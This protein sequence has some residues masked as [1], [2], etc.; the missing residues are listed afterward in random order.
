MQTMST[1]TPSPAPALP[2]EPAALIE[3]IL[4]RFHEVHRQQ[5]PE[6]IR[7]ATQVESRHADHPAA[8][9]GLATLLKSMHA[10]LLQ[11]MDKEESI[12]F[13]MLARGGSP[14]VVH[15]IAVMRSEHEEHVANLAQ[16]MTLTRHAEPPADA[17]STWRQLCACVRQFADDLEQHI[18]IEN[19]CLFPAFEAIRR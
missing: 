11:H 8:P 1:T 9:H 10:E 2:R 5:V 15:P 13:P 19:E 18:R 4:E 3:Y 17:C 14:F 6:L 16:L 12:L 7:L